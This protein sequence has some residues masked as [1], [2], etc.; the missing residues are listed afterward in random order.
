ML[1]RSQDPRDEKT[2]RLVQRKVFVLGEFQVEFVLHAVDYY[3]A[4][5]LPAMTEPARHYAS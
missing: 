4:L 5:N 1:D 2:I 3:F